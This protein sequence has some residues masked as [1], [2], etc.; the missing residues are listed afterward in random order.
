MSLIQTFAALR[1]TAEYAAAVAAPPYDVLSTAEARQL[2]AGRPWSFLHI[3]RAEVDLPETTD[4][5]APE[6]YAQARANLERMLAA[7]VLVRDSEPGYSVYRLTWGAHVQTGCVVAA[8]IAAYDAGRIKKHELTRPTKEADRVRQIEALNAQTGPVLLVHRATPE[9]DATLAALADAHA[10][11]YD[12]T[13]PGGVRHQLWR[14]TERAVIEQLTQA[15][16]RLDSLYIAD[17]H[18]RSAAASRVAAL[19]HDPTAGF[20]AVTFPHDQLSILDYNRLVRDLNGLAPHSFVQQVAT[21]CTVEPVTAPLAPERAG[22]VGMYQAGQWY[23]LT[24]AEQSEQ[25]ADP[26]AALDVSRL[27][28]Q[29]LGPL[30]GISDPRRDERLECVGGIRGLAGLTER[31]DSGEMAVAFALYPTSVAELM[32]VAD[33]GAIM[34]PKSTWFEPKL[35]DG[36]VSLLFSGH[37]AET[38]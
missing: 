25:S 21:R 31:V 37:E 36:L 28:H 18:H 17:G 3:S 5:Y 1:P 34:P 7:G 26:V 20:L 16:E 4:P 24:L 9:I 14:I 13:A 27:Q 32:A 22:V 19:R 10:P 2:V 30:L 6:V 35:A 33:Q 12:L 23:R 8:S 11:D 29:I 38:S 15:F